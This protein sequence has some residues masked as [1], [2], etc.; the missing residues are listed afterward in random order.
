[1]SEFAGKTAVITGGASGMGKLSG[2]NL[3][4]Q[5]AN[6]VLLDVNEEALRT[7]VAEMKVSTGNDHILGIAAD[8]RDY[9]QVVSARDQAVEA[10]GSIDYLLNIAG[11]AASRVFGCREEF[12]DVPMEVINWGIDVNLKG[13]INMDHACFDQ[14]AK[15]NSGVIIHMGSITGEEGGGSVD[16]AAAKSALMYG[17]TKSLATYGQKYNV[18]VCCVSP[19]PVLTRPGMAKMKTLMGRAADPQEIVDLILYLISDKASFI[20]GTNYLI[21]GGRNVLFNKG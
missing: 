13:A 20:T 8:I 12:K 21:D 15:Q 3:A 9:D 19:G 7:V 14:F 6:V 18:R 17:V 16:Y 2:E 10:F 5:G 11:G 1:M 4:A